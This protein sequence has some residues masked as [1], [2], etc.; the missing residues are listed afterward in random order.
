METNTFLNHQG[1]E[2]PVFG[3]TL[4]QVLLHIYDFSPG[5]ALYLPDDGPYAANTPC[6]VADPIAYPPEE[7]T[8]L[9]Q[10]CVSQGFEIWFNI[11]IVS[12][13]CDDAAEQTESCLLAVFNQD[14]KTDGWLWKN[15]N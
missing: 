11:A 4:G 13:T 12:D 14:C 2:F 15:R 1:K 6:I 7:H 9:H 5:A 3:S 8:L 10:A